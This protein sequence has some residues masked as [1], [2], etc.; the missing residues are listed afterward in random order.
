[1]RLNYL[2]YVWALTLPVFV[3]EALKFAVKFRGNIIRSKLLRTFTLSP[4]GIA[5]A[6][7]KRQNCFKTV[8]LY[9]AAHTGWTKP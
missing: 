8:Y 9:F 6:K 1:M 4:I 5:F 3:S 2:S 7:F